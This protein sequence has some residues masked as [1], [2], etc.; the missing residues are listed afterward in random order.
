[1]NIAIQKATE[2]GVSR[3]VPC[4]TQNTNQLKIN[5]RNLKMNIIEAA[6]QSERLTIPLLEQ[7]TKLNDLLDNNL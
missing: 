4:I 1:M 6:E 2:L 3:F 5:I 7:I